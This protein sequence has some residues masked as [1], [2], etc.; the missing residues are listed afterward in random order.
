[1]QLFFF[2]AGTAA[3]LELVSHNFLKLVLKL[4]Q[5]ETYLKCR[6]ANIS[7]TSRERVTIF[8]CVFIET[9][10]PY[11]TDCSIDITLLVHTLSVV[12]KA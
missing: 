9:D 5:K 11:P 7:L 1:M 10:S 8:M 6:G 2:D 4:L 12:P 3:V